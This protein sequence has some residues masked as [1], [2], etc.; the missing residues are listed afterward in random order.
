MER[1]LAAALEGQSPAVCAFWYGK[2]LQALEQEKDG[3]ECPTT[4]SMIKFVVNKTL[5][6]HQI[7]ALA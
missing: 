3:S 5:Q 4:G 2:F 1:C 6:E 7:D